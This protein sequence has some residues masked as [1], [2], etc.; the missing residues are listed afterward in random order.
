MSG[1]GFKL[2]LPGYILLV[3]SQLLSIGQ[4]PSWAP[5]RGCIRGPG[6]QG[7][8]ESA[9]L[10]FSFRA[11]RLPVKHNLLSEDNSRKA[12]HPAWGSIVRFAVVR[13]EIFSCG[14]LVLPL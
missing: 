13:I 12:V 14:W 11:G 2:G 6:K 9:G 10:P 5:L 4:L 1:L 7:T 8:P 3:D